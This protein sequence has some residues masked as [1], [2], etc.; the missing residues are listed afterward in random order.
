[1]RRPGMCHHQD[2]EM[3]KYADGELSARDAVE[4]RAH[5]EACWECRA[6]LEDLQN[7]V[8]QCVGYRKNVLQRHLPPPPAPWTDIYQRFTEIDAVVARPSFLDRAAQVLRWPMH[9]AKK[10]VPV[11]VATILVSGLYYRFHKTPS[12]LASELLGKAVV[13]AETRV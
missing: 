10:W 11:S 6:A 1:M 8:S 13:A 2:E 9:N 5:L 12:L 4:I 3:L 7:T